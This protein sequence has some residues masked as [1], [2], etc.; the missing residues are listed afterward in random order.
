MIH[1]GLM[2]GKIHESMLSLSRVI[3]RGATTRDLQHELSRRPGVESMQLGPEDQ[4]EISVRGP[5]T[6]SV[7]VD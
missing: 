6:V 5:A 4:Q 1:R 7:N 3:L 2:R